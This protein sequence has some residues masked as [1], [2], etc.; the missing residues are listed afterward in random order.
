MR[1]QMTEPVDVLDR[2]DPFTCSSPGEQVI[3]LSWACGH[4]QLGGDLAEAS[5]EG[6]SL[7]SMPT[8]CPTGVTGTS[9][10]P[11]RPDRPTGPIS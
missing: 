11:C 5:F 10:R 9:G 4:T 8:G 6:N 1:Q 3:N 2:P 7:G